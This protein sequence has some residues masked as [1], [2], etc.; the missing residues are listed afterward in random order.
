VKP[1][2]DSEFLRV[3]FVEY[4]KGN[5]DEWLKRTEIER[6]TGAFVNSQEL[7]EKESDSLIKSLRS[8]RDY[9][10]KF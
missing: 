2:N 3:N 5:R 6:V 9:A 7:I 8:L 10:K 1:G 4:P